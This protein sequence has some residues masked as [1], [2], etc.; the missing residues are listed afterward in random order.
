MRASVAMDVI[1]SGCVYYSGRNKPTLIYIDTPSHVHYVPP[2]VQE[3]SKDYRKKAP[4]GLRMLANLG[5]A[6]SPRFL[7]TSSSDWEILDGLSTQQGPNYAIAKLLQR[8][9]A[10]YSRAQGCRVSITTGPPAK[11]DSVMHSKTMAFVMNHAHEVQP[12]TAHMPET[13]QSLMS[14]IMIRDCHS[15]KALGA[16]NTI[17]EDTSS[18]KHIM[19]FIVENAWH[20][21]MWCAPYDM[22]SAAVYL[23]LKHYCPSFLISL[24]ALSV[25]GLLFFL[26]K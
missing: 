15:D 14:I 9:R 2:K 11:T 20:G 19:E 5:F 24:A 4:R 23:Y 3:N 16:R 22:K 8:W 17:D 13:V 25:A 26:N 7:S 6:K 1:V 21:G 18:S 12:N 10:L